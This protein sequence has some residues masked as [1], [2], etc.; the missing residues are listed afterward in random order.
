MPNCSQLAQFP[1]K[2]VEALQGGRSGELATIGQARQDQCQNRSTTKATSK[3]AHLGRRSGTLS[4]N[5][6]AS[7]RRSRI[8]LVRG[9]VCA[10]CS[11][12]LGSIKVLNKTPNIQVRIVGVTTVWSLALA[13][14]ALFVFVFSVSDDWHF[15]TA[16]IDCPSRR[17]L[18]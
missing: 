17:S 2:G 18:I 12:S 7:I 9:S 16:A 6:I 13:V 11:M 4:M 5:S 3:A 8:R 10:I 14:A 1:I 15:S